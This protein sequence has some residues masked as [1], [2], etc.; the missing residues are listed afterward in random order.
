MKVHSTYVST[1]FSESTNVFRAGR[2]NVVGLDPNVIKLHY[3]Y[4]QRTL[5]GAD[6]PHTVGTRRT[7]TE[8]FPGWGGG[9]SRGGGAWHPRM[10]CYLHPSTVRLPC[11]RNT[12]L[13][14]LTGCRSSSLDYTPQSYAFRAT[15]TLLY[16]ALRLRSCTQQ[17]SSVP[18]CVWYSASAAHT[19]FRHIVL[20]AAVSAAAALNY[21]RLI[22]ALDSVLSLC[23]TRRTPLS[24][25]AAASLLMLILSCDFCRCLL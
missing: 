5:L 10:H 3:I 14:L 20:S 6:P 9:S 16:A 12:T 2:T 1:A 24:P 17:S 11:Q 21:S 7:H 8:D 23:V 4:F 19:C 15:A 13:L 22:G 25:A 18:L